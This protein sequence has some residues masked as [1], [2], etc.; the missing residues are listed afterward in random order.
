VRNEI[1]VTINENSS[2]AAR[3]PTD[4]LTQAL[5]QDLVENG[6]RFSLCRVSENFSGRTM[7]FEAHRGFGPGSTSVVVSIP[8]QMV[9]GTPRDGYSKSLEAMDACF[10]RVRR[11]LQRRYPSDRDLEATL[12]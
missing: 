9:I 7:E 2:R 12:C 4:T 11:E 3:Q 1:V 6:V 5:L 8:C 10:G